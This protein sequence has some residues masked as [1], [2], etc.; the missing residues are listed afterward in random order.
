MTPATVNMKLPSIRSPFSSRIFFGKGVAACGQECATQC[1]GEPVHI[2]PRP[3]N[4]LRL[5]LSIHEPFSGASLY[6]PR[7]FPPSKFDRNEGIH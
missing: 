2:N 7:A 6:V 3:T 1:N 4:P 5:D